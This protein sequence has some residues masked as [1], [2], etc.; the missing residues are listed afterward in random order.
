[1]ETSPI[2]MQ[3]KPAAR[4]VAAATAA[5]GMPAALKISGLTTTI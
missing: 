4:Q 3:P 1:L 2:K 5:A